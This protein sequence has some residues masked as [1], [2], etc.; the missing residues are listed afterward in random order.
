MT[1]DPGDPEILS[2]PR[3]RALFRRE[4]DRTRSNAAT[5]AYRFG[6]LCEA[7][8][9]P[10]AALVK[11]AKE[12]GL[13]AG[14]VEGHANCLRRLKR[15]RRQAR[16]TIASPRGR[17]GEGEGRADPRHRGG[18]AP[19]PLPPESALR[20]RERDRA[21]RAPALGGRRPRRAT[22]LGGELERARS[23]QGPPAALGG[24]L[25]CGDGIPG[26]DDHA[27]GRPRLRPHPPIR[28]SS[29]PTS[30]R[31]RCVSSSSRRAPLSPSQNTRNMGQGAREPNRT[32]AST[33]MTSS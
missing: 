8:D 17:S 33:A 4:L 3:R 14:Y 11:L 1:R 20:A 23:Q 9:P 25:P 27:A 12:M 19:G 22:A 7:A 18:R 6:H 31:I 30:C 13:L 21:V 26:R 10:L 24:A 32:N 2:L 28:G 15:A 5:L 29:L 16:A